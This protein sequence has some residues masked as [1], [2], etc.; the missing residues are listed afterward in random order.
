MPVEGA[1]AKSR[2]R[3]MHAASARG[4]C[5]AGEDFD[6]AEPDPYEDQEEECFT[7]GPVYVTAETVARDDVH[8][9]R[10]S[11][12][13][14]R[15]CG[16]DFRVWAVPLLAA[17]LVLNN[18]RFVCR[19]LRVRSMRP[20]ALSALSHSSWTASEARAHTRHT[21]TVRRARVARRGRDPGPS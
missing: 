21:A 17:R 9:M 19:W 4:A 5:G 14:S 6:N 12:S 3:G 20:G 10:V 18:V 8:G 1:R 15:V 13:S 2:A 7:Q 16:L 11:R